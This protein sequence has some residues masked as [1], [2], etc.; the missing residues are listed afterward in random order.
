LDVKYHLSLFA[1]HEYEEN[2]IIISP[3]KPPISCC[4]EKNIFAW[5]EKYFKVYTR[6]IGYTFLFL[7]SSLFFILILK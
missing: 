6:T 5:Y 7:T 1:S 3:N 4:N 2:G